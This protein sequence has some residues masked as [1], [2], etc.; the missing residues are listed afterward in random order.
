MHDTKSNNTVRRGPNFSAAA[1]MRSNERKGA[2][3]ERLK[4]V[5]DAA[6]AEAERYAESYPQSSDGRNTFLMFADW[7]LSLSKGSK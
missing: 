7:L 3:V 4:A 6:V 5:L 1:V 2:E